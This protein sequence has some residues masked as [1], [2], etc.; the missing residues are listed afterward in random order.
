M[1]ASVV[2][3][4]LI[5]SAIWGSTWLFIKI[6]LEDLPPLTFAGTRFVIAAIL[7]FGVVLA[8][9]VP[10]PRER[11]D[12]T[13][14]AATGVLSFTLNYGLVFWGEQHV[15][16]GL[17]ALLQATIPVFGLVIAH[18]YL[19]GE[20]ITVVK[21][22]GVL[23]GIAGVG[24]IFSDQVSFRGSL[25]LLGSAAI[26]SGAFAAAYANV[27]VK[28]RGGHLDPAMLAFGQMIFGLVPLLIGGAAT[29]GNPMNFNWTT[30]AWI[31]L[32]YLAVV[33]SALA[34]MLYYWLVKNM[35]VTKTMLIALVT[36][37]L[38]VTLGILILNEDLTWRIVTGGAAILGGVGLIITRSMP[39]GLTRNMPRKVRHAEN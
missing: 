3:V 13:L 2:I 39:A 34:F 27:L 22:I 25:A 18:Y 31:A 37:L 26:V 35:D 19:P 33:G 15:S 9:R 4:F 11:S 16:S 12:W 20:R 38:A 10:L 14:M 32:I 29:E 24:V 30:R 23:L 7:L 36:P 21:T 8:R 28:A 6:G 17:A 1:S 5:L